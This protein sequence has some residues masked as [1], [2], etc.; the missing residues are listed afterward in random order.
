MKPKD[1]IYLHIGMHKTGTTSI[2]NSLSSYDDGT[3]RYARVGPANHSMFIK[4][5]FGSKGADYRIHKMLGRSAAEIDEMKK[6]YRIQLIQELESPAKKLVFCGEDIGILTPEELLEFRD[7]LEPYTEE[8]RVV[9]YVREPYGFASSMFQQDVKAG[10]AEFSIRAPNYYRKFHKFVEVFG[11]SACDFIYFSP[12][13][14]RNKC[15]VV[16]F[17][18]RVG[19]SAD[20]ISIR[21]DNDSLSLKGVALLYGWNRDGVESSG[22]E[23]LVHARHQLISLLRDGF[24]GKFVLDPVCVERSVEDSDVT[25]MQECS[26]ID[27][28]VRG[29]QLSST[30]VVIGSHA[31]LLDQQ[32]AAVPA[33]KLLLEQRGI[34]CN[35]IDVAAKI[36][37]RLFLH[38]LMAAPA[39]NRHVIALR[40]IAIKLEKSDAFELEEAHELMALA[41]AMR[42]SSFIKGKLDQYEKAMRETSDEKV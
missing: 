28:A 21:R 33:L 4:A 1:V 9:V 5:L 6:R 31:Q 36:L 41:Y 2:Q 40:D 15:V 18:D 12:T 24:E 10:L 11:R 38:L 30:Q 32:S 35:D 23:K 14:F 29:Q 17:C 3:L 42:P 26:G 25:W 7:Y 39:E 8:F 34:S 20:S 19:I 13:S 37:D 27:L 16:D 22:T